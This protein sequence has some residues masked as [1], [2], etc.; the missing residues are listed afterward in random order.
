[1]VSQDDRQV[2]RLHGGEAVLAAFGL[3]T[4]VE[5]GGYYFPWLDNLLDSVATPAAVVAGAV[6]TASVVG[7]ISP[8]LRWIL[9]AIVL[10][11]LFEWV[12]F[13]GFNFIPRAF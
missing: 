3:A 4:A 11:P 6:I 2:Q 5:I 12:G 8:M 13:T 1:M 7:D 10:W 9:A